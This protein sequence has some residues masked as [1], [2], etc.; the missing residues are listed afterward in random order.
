MSLFPAAPALA[1]GTASGSV[2]SFVLAPANTALSPCGGTMAAPGDWISVKGSGTFDPAAK[3]VTA[4]GSFVHYS[5]TGTAVCT[6]TWKAT[7]FTSFTDF[8]SNDQGEEG[9]VLSMVVT[10]YCTTMGMTMT[11]IPMTVTSTVD[12]P[13]GSTYVRAP[14]CVTSPSQP[15]A[16]WRSSP[17]SEPAPSAR[18]GSRVRRL[19]P[20]TACR[21]LA[22]A[23]SRIARPGM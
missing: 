15:A 5:S 2:F 1:A 22:V 19:R 6:G 10:H 16:A 23:H 14:R 17:T 7:G 12:A 3:T 18:S 20:V 8:G 13:A 21:E 9:G 11:N 4:K